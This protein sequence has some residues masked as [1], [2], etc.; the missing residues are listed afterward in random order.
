MTGLATAAP[1]SIG[2]TKLLVL[3]TDA[4]GGQRTGVIVTSP[5]L[6]VARIRM[7]KE[8][9]LPAVLGHVQMMPASVVPLICL[10]FG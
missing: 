1:V 6:R 9:E 3:V 10:R 5:R 8:V 2:T 4:F 7:A